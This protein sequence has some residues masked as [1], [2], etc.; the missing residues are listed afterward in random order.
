MTPLRGHNFSLPAF[1]TPRGWLRGDPNVASRICW[2]QNSRMDRGAYPSDIDDD[3]YTF[4]LPYLALT[5]ED[6]PQR[7]YPLREVLNALLWMSRTGSQW[8]F[9]PH[10]L[11][12]A[13]VVR[14]QA[15]RWFEA[16]CFENAVHDL[17]L[18]S[19]VQQQRGGEP[20]A[21]IIDSRTLQSG[22][23]PHG[24]R[25]AQD[26]PRRAGTARDSTARKNARAPRCTSWL[27]PSA[28]C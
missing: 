20:S 1:V 7:K 3:A 16:H 11:P 15:K 9:L 5:P 26:A 28:I 19:R 8:A 27:T 10:D 2:W 13:E 6:A 17:R 4:L 21:I 12:P 18:F 24:C 23:A 25:S 22:Q 14:S